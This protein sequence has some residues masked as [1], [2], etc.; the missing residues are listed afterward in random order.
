MP[1][2]ADIVV[3]SQDSAEVL[4]VVEAKTA[5][6]DRNTVESELGRYMVTT[7]C[8][9]GLLVSP[10]HI[11][12][13][14]NLFKESAPTSVERVGQYRN[15]LTEFALFHRDDWKSGAAFQEF[16]QSWLEQLARNREIHTPSADLK[17]AIKIY[18]LPALSVGVI[19]AAGP[20][21]FL[22]RA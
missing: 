2:A 17:E 6:R 20:R 4:L 7:S 18:V 22:R 1:L 10:E 12:V 11:S 5:V 13:Y 19:R 3:T 15:D 14:R 8:P 9:V 16:V 21:E